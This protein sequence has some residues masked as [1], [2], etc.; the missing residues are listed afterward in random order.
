M[1]KFTVVLICLCLLLCSCNYDKNSADTEKNSAENNATQSTESNPQEEHKDVF[2]EAKYD[3]FRFNVEIKNLIEGKLKETS[4]VDGTVLLQIVP[5]EVFYLYYY[6]PKA[7]IDGN[8]ENVSDTY[9]DFRYLQYYVEC[10]GSDFRTFYESPG[11][12]LGDG[13]DIDE[14]E[15]AKCPDFSLVYDYLSHPEKLFDDS[16]Q[17]NNVIC[18]STVAD[19]RM[20]E[21]HYK[22]LSRKDIFVYYKTSA[23][24]YMLYVPF[25][26]EAI[27]PALPKY[28]EGN[29]REIGYSDKGY[30]LPIEKVYDAWEAMKVNHYGESHDKPRFTAYEGETQLHNLID[31]KPFEISIETYIKYV[32]V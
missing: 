32:L 9:G 2:V 21:I 12:A 25:E 1:K 29:Y 7:N 24:N 10:E 22:N 15:D 14:N 26:Y 5:S 3:C 27:D 11:C 13:S 19:V 18:F 8:W 31:L 28:Q 23:G 17:V 4:D 20:S 30:L 6:I 16:V